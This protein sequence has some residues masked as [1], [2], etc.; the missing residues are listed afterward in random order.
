MKVHGYFRSG[1]AWRV[2]IALN[3]K[4]IAPEQASVHLRKQ[5]QA[6]P[7]FRSL[8]PQGLV[9][10]LEHEGARLTQSLAIIEYLEEIQPQPPLLP[11]DPLDRAWVR[12]IALAIAC[13]IHPLDNLRVLRYLE[14][15]L[16]IDEAGRN[17]WYAHWVAQGFGPLEAMLAA[18]PRTGRFC[19]GDTPTLADICLIP[20]MGNAAR[21]K[22]SLD[23]YP[24]LRRIAG[25]ARALPAF[26][27]AEPDVQPDAQ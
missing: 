6:L 18:D 11:R 19:C 5:E 16:G 7:A 14:D 20:Q 21:M 8:N 3:L 26:A 4:G 24:T 12:G 25:N 22:C 27:A 23:P 9:P 17:R 13:D 10:V 1:A 2:R 15:P